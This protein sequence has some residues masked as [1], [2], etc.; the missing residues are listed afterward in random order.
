[1]PFHPAKTGKTPIDIA[2]RYSDVW[3]EEEKF[4]LTLELLVQSS[5]GRNAQSTDKLLELDRPALVLV[6]DIEDVVCELGWIAKGEELAVD[7]LELC[8]SAPSH[9]LMQMCSLNNH[10]EILYSVRWYSARQH[11]EERN[12]EE[13]GKDDAKCESRTLLVELSTW[14]IFNETLVLPISSCLCHGRR[15][16]PIAGAPA[17]CQY[18]HS[19]IKPY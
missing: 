16:S 17:W 12:G 7:F 1:M 3:E 18:R 15:D 11:E 10:Y 8:P 19:I 6:K 5:P 2:F 4:V 14:A 13:A 9:L